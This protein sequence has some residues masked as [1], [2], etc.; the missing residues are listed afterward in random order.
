MK[1]LAAAVVTVLVLGMGVDVE[2]H[3]GGAYRGG[4]G[5]VVPPPMS[6]DRDLVLPPPPPG[7]APRK[8]P[9]PE[10]QRPSPTSI[11]RSDWII[12]YHHNCEPLEQTKRWLYALVSSGW[13]PRRET[14]GRDPGDGT[15]F[16]TRRLRKTK[17]VPALLRVIA[18]RSLPAATRSSALLALGK[19]TEEPAHVAVLR[20]QLE[21]TDPGHLDLPCSA[22]IGLGLLR[23]TRGK[24]RF[25]AEA[26]DGVRRVLLRVLDAP[27]RSSR[28]RGAAAL[29]LGLLGDQPGKAPRSIT[30]SLMVHLA[31]PDAESELVVAVL[32][33]AALQPR[34]T[35]Q[36]E[37]IELLR[38]RIRPKATEFAV[39]GSAIGAKAIEALGRVG[40]AAEIDRLGVLLLS[41]RAGRR[42][43]ESS[44]VALGNIAARVARKDLTRIADHLIKARMRTRSQYVR[45]FSI[46][47]LAEVGLADLALGRRGATEVVRVGQLL[48]RLVADG[49]FGERAYAA[50][51][52]ARIGAAIG[53]ESELKD[54]AELH[55]RT[56][57][58]VRAGLRSKQVH[59]RS[60]AAFVVG[61]GLLEDGR[62]RGALLQIVANPKADQDLAAYSALALGLIGHGSK[63]QFQ[64][65]RKLVDAREPWAVRHMA[66]KALVFMHRRSAQRLQLAALEQAK[67]DEVR[68]QILVTLGETGAEWAIEPLIRVVEGKAH[69]PVVRARAVGALGRVCDL[70]DVP[71]LARLTAGTNYLASSQ[72]LHWIRTLQ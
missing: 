28:I 21:A 5:R 19:A 34:E 2:S 33:A 3:D 23:R 51:A 59:L 72:L 11:N 55:W 57:E 13:T 43:S 30:K 31:D 10:H 24:E 60:R 9:K 48:L 68:A 29:G 1:R 32:C 12:W 62:S 8:R 63:E 46:M 27:K 35:F 39:H 26:L 49:R 70:E 56:L 41:R 64:A 15:T 38:R 4:R 25:S 18:D 50:L 53:E 54:L 52:I 17:A 45:A 66:T 16:D 58:A 37:D 14:L 40:D 7:Q 61:L 36:P 69:S 65:L 20:E 47:A 67:T 71:S 42:V 6:R 22:A 44:A